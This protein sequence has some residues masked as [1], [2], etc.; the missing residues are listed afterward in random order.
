MGCAPT[1]L[2]KILIITY[3]DEYLKAISHIITQKTFEIKDI[4]F[5]NHRNNVRN[6]LYTF[7][8]NKQKW[9]W[10]HQFNG[11]YGTII[12]YE[13]KDADN[14]KEIENI[15][16]SSI[17]HKR[18]LLLLFDKNKITDKEYQFF[19]TIRYNLSLKNVKMLVQFIDFSFNHSNSELLYG[20][21]WLY[22]E[23]MIHNKI[24]KL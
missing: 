16:N 1:V 13:G 15:L 24:K 8:S 21:D 19:E 17:L 7:L 2:R 9:T 12:V 4:N 23:I 18:P 6:I 22:Q 11:T 10:I 20:L 3:D 14:I 5:I